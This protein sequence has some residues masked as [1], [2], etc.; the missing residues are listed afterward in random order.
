MSAITFLVFGTDKLLA[1]K[2]K[3][4]VPEKH[5]VSLSLFGGGVGAVLGIKLFRHKTKHPL[6]VI[7]AVFG[8]ILNIAI[9]ALTIYF[10]I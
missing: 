3:R 5:L 2:N 4:R 7:P 1:I 6:I 10:E 9:I 8:A